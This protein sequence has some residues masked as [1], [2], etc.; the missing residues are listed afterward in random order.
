MYRHCL[1]QSA[2]LGKN[3]GGSECSGV[4]PT[5]LIVWYR[6]HVPLNPNQRNTRCPVSRS[7][8]PS[9]HPHPDPTPSTC[10]VSYEG[11]DCEARKQSA[12]KASDLW[13]QLLEI[14]QRVIWTNCTTVSES[15]LLGLRTP[16]LPSPWGSKEKPGG[17]NYRYL[18][19]HGPQTLL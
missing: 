12:S 6:E 8:C 9:P 18:E 1:G 4:K 16:P 14:L 13:H 19:P 17:R 7:G 2:R 5:N 3:G 10:L 11:Q 15:F